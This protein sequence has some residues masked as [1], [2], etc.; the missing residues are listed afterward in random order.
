MN[1]FDTSLT[2]LCYDTN[3]KVSI[4]YQSSSTL[5]FTASV[6]VSSLNG[7]I[8]QWLKLFTTKLLDD[9]ELTTVHLKQGVNLV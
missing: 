3:N 8:K 7:E 6:Y 9:T 1:V 5:H 4:S 2:T